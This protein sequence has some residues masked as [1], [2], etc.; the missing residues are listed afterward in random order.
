MS[1]I[2]QLNSDRYCAIT[3]RGLAPGGAAVRPRGPP[4]VQEDPEVRAAGGGRR[5]RRRG[6]PGG[7]RR[8]RLSFAYDA[9]ARLSIQPRRRKR[10]P[11]VCLDLS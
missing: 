2:K 9:N 10:S 8:S 1:Q 7:A 4:L 11:R 5:E 6:S 3:E